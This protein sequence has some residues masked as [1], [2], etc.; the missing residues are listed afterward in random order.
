MSNI[1]EAFIAG[2]THKFQ[3]IP[4][5]AVQ[6]SRKVLLD[7]L[8]V[9]SGG[10]KYLEEKHPKLTVSDSND[11]FLRGFAAHVLELDDGHRKG[12]IHLGA[13][14][15]SAI[16]EVAKR[17]EV[18]SVNVLNGIIMGYE[19]AVRCA[20]AIQP[21]HKKR[22]YHVSGTC[23]TIGSA[24]G[25][26]FACGYSKEQLKSTLTC[27]V[28]SAAGVLEI[29]E[30]ASELKPYNLGRAALGGVV[31]AQIGEL[32]L[33]GPEDILGGKRGFL[34][35]LTD[36][37]KPD[38]LTNFDGEVYCIE[39]IYQKEYAACRHCHPAI[40][41][42]LCIR[43]D[44]QAE[45]ELVDR[46]EVHTYQ[47]AVGS[48]DHTEIMGIS[49]A[50]LSTPYAVALSIVKGHAGYA[51]YNET[52]LNDC[53]IKMLTRKVYVLEDDHLTA[54]SPSIRGA[55]VS[56]YMKDG[57]SYE[58]TCLYPKGEPENPMSEEELV[59][60]FRNL[61]IYGGITLQEINKVIAELQ[62]A[63]FN[64]NKILNIICRKS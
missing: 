58:A 64:L 24:M 56:V 31:A 39:G 55:R 57:K 16:L 30:Q 59:E 8:G 45:P 26:A 46:I 60:K 38:Y 42:I 19:A 34:A 27:A 40:D 10:K 54:Q 37:P 18:K 32:A 17:G 15:I 2:L 4:D 52:N 41:A 44:I 35:V 25:I 43:K 12:M 62:K 28:S 33:P 50:K 61:A 7:Y 13:S 20:C 49:S 3:T 29:Q 1:T 9:L 11:A 23:G 47:L 22:G 53:T 21:S 48:H 51:D 6:Q 63:E 36:T 14:I 5:K